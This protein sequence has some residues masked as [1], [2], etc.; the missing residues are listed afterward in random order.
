MWPG[1]KQIGAVRWLQWVIPLILLLG[2]TAVFWF[3]DVDRDLAAHF[4]EPG[5]GWPLGASQPWA[6]LKHYGVV[7]AWVLS[8]SALFLLLVSFRVRR[9]ARHRKSFLFLVL[10][11]IIGPGL[12]VNVVFKDHWGRPRP[13]DLVE[14]GGAK[15][16][17]PVWV[18]NE[19]SGGNAFPSG[20]AATA[21]YLF[22]PFFLLYRH[23]NGLAA[24]FLLLGLTYGALMGLARIL[25]GAHFL[26]DVVW[27][28]GLVYVIG[29]MLHRLLRIDAPATGDQAPRR[30]SW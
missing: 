12:V 10:V 6:F 11:M 27:A 22:T 16:F 4:Y 28:A 25:Q 17:V 23:R 30:S 1:K 26:S 7:P 15:Q 29:A 19:A 18:K 2:S 9:L 14:F 5:P 21:F 3:T 8:L 24:L 13:R 20:H